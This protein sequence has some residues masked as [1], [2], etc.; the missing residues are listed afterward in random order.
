[1]LPRQRVGIHERTGQLVLER[2]FSVDLQQALKTAFLDVEDYLCFPYAWY[3]SDDGELQILS[4][5]T[6]AEEE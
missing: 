1:M 6:S 5:T 3:D 2:G 4:M